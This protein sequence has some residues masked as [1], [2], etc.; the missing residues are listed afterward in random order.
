M[1]VN[2]IRRLERAENTKPSWMRSE[3]FRNIAF[4]IKSAVFM[5]RFGPVGEEELVSRVR[6]RWYEHVERKDKSDWVSACRVLDVEG[7]KE[8]GRGERSGT[9]G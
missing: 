8:T 4:M 2:F 6:L 5:D 9:S 1:K 3:T 7:T